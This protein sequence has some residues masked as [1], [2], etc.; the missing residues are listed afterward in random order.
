MTLIELE[1]TT[2]SLAEIAFHSNY[3]PATQAEMLHD[4]R[5]LLPGTKQSFFSFLSNL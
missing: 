4:L 3:H 5:Q 2:L 1:G